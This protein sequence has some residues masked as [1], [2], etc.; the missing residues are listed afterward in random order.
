MTR[1]TQTRRCINIPAAMYER[2]SAWCEKHGMARSQF[3]EMVLGDL[4][5]AKKK[6]WRE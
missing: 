4:P 6:A 3:V 1:Q 2:L 5:P